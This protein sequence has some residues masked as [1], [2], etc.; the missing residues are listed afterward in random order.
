MSDCFIG[1]IRLFGFPRIPNGWAVCDGSTLPIR[2]NEALYS[3]IGISYGGDGINNFKLPD[4]RGRVPIAQGTGP[5]LSART[6]AQ[7]G[8]EE[9]HTLTENELPAHS[10]P[11][12]ASTAPATTATPGN[13]V[14]LAT[15]SPATAK[16]FAPQAS[17]TGYMVM[18][19]SVLPS[20]G[21]QPHPNMM[22]SQAGNYCIALTGVYPAKP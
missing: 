8:G 3:L 11:L 21:S 6:I 17:I 22:P 10:H 18:A 15:A 12:I 9:A 1:E 5:G 20:G 2:G 19:P 16:L 14:Q 7:Q 4:L 13:N